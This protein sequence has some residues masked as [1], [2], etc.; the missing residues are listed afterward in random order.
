M[1]AQLPYG[2]LPPIVT[3]EE[4]G[5]LAH[6]QSAGITTGPLHMN[7]MAGPSNHKGLVGNQQQQQYDSSGF[8]WQFPQGQTSHQIYNNGQSN[9]SQGTWAWNDGFNSA[10]FQDSR[11]GDQGEAGS[12]GG[13][14]GSIFPNN[15][16]PSFQ[17]PQQNPFRRF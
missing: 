5:L 1:G 14:G 3:L 16:Q 6:G 4:S 10:S 15:G 13:S 12:F 2:R 8:G 7:A 9:N 11:W 17:W